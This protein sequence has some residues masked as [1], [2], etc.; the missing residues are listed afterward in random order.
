MK[1][2]VKTLVSLNNISL[3]QFET[4]ER[5]GFPFKPAGPAI[6]KEGLIIKE[7]MESGVVSKLLAI[8][9]NRQI[10]TCDLFGNRDSFRYYFPGLKDAALMYEMPGKQVK[11]VEEA[12]AFY[13][14]DEFLDLVE[15]D[16]MPS[17]EQAAGLGKIRRIKNE[18]IDFVNIKALCSEAFQP[19]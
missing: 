8:I 19:P 14:L 17:V 9:M 5:D 18:K 1:T 6:E 7:F 12:E 16:L 4:L 15:K 3:L 10:A 2:F 11:P 13:K